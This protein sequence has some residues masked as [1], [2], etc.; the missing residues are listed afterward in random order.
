MQGEEEEEE[1]EEED[2]DDVEEACGQLLAH[3]LEQ[4]ENFS[5]VRISVCLPVCLSLRPSV[6]LSVCMSACLSVC[7]PVCLCI[8]CVSGQHGRTT[9]QLPHHI[10]TCA[11]ACVCT[12]P[13]TQTDQSPRHHTKN[14][15][16]PSDCVLAVPAS[17]G[18]EERRAVIHACNMAGLS[19]LYV[20]V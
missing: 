8:K 3:V 12:S 19:V 9:D 2:D 17:F 18:E 4:A 10:T 20:D 13:L 16:S 5:G 1:Q 14:Q 6:C 7:R 11:R 15:E